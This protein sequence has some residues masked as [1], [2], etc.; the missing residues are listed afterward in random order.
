MGLFWRRKMNDQS[1][2]IRTMLRNYNPIKVPDYQRA[3][4]WEVDTDKKQV[5][6]F[7]SDINDYV[8]SNSSSPYYLGNFLFE[9]R[10]NTFYVID[11]Q[12]RLTTIQICLSSIFKFLEK[13]ETEDEKHQYADM[14]KWDTSYHFSTVEYDNL[15]FRD[16][17]INQTTQ[18]KKKLDTESK[19]RIVA[20]FDYFNDYFVGK[21]EKYLRSILLAISNATCQAYTVRNESEGI[22]MFIFQNDRGKK[23]THLEV[24]KAQFMYY[25]HLYAGKEKN[26]ILSEIKIRFEEIYKSIAK[27]ERGINEDSVL[28]NALCIHY[29]TLWGDVSSIDKQ[30]EEGEPEETVNFIQSFSKC[31]SDCFKALTDFYCDENSQAQSLTVLGVDVSLLPFIIKAYLFGLE[32]TKKE[33]LFSYLESLILR[34]KVIRSRADL[35]TRLQDVYKTFT[36]KNKEI[37][38]I[39]NRITNLRTATDYWHSFW[40]N[41]SFA[42]ALDGG[43]PHNVAKFILW[44]YENYLLK[45]SGGYSRPWTDIKNPQLEHIAPQSPTTDKPEKNGYCK[46]D[47]EFYQG[48]LNCLGN[49]LLLAGSHNDSISN[50]PFAEKRKTYTE[51]AQQRE[52]QEM[53][54]DDLVWNKDKIDKRHKKLVNFLLSNF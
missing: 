50:G 54:K 32:D 22:Q 40:N 46:Y 43:L 1:I 19:K 4:S 48:Y 8:K 31:L 21:D 5:T 42:T 33:K 34:D 35:T 28:R 47:D 29:N 17:V 20:A 36:V 7:L 37:S 53:T 10:D 44:K 12:Q 9:E 25:I 24:I 15:F 52:V 45:N 39:I 26:N 6:Q 14:V 51:L 13:N 16:Y 2:S 41:D 27:I 11:G 49:Y 23:P 3:Y 30:L 38:E 18:N